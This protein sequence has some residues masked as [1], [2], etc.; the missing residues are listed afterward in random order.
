MQTARALA[1]RPRLLILDKPAGGMN[2]QE[3]EG[4]GN[5]IKKMR[6]RGVTILLI[7]HDMELVMKV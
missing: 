3:T 7:E 4:P 1:T 2:D 6:A 5:L